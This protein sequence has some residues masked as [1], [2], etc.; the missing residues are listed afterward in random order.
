[1]VVVHLTNSG[2]F[3]LPPSEPE[4]ADSVRGD[5]EARSILSDLRLVVHIA[6]ASQAEL[7]MVGPAGVVGATYGL[8][9]KKS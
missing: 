6:N 3:L 7:Q 5:E 9:P 1:M 8:N 2:T 4:D